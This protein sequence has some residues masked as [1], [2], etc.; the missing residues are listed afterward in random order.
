MQTRASRFIR[1]T[2]SGARALV[3]SFERQVTRT[4]IAGRAS[5]AWIRVNLSSL[6]P[7]HPSKAASSCAEC[8]K[9]KLRRVIIRPIG[10]PGGLALV[11]AGPFNPPLHLHQAEICSESN[12]LKIVQIRPFRLPREQDSSSNTSRNGHTWPLKRECT[13]Y[14]LNNLPHQ[15]ESPVDGEILF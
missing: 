10:L 13:E 5:F 3:Y 4:F 11:I 12:R 7:I 15:G 8:A 2:L 6:Y 9:L 14:C 1:S